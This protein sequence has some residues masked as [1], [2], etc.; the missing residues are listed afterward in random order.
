MARNPTHY[1]RLA[2]LLILM[3]GLGIFAASFGGTLQRSFEERA[4]YETG[5]DV[6][7]EGVILSSTGDSLPMRTVFEGLQPVED[8]TLA[9]RGFGS[10]LSKLLADSYIM[11]AVEGEKIREVGWFRDD[12]SESSMRSML[13]SLASDTLPVGIEAP[14]GA[15]SIGVTF[16]PD[17]P[18]PSVAVASRIRDANGRY[19][20]YIMGA[21]D[22][23]EWQTMEHSLDRPSRRGRRALRPQSPVSVVSFSI[24]ETSGRNRLRAGS[25]VI[26][27]IFARM[28]DGDRKVLEA[29]ESPSEWTMLRSVPEADA[30]LLKPADF[31]MNNSSAVNLIWAEG[32]PLVSRGIFHGPPLEPLPAI[33]SSRFIKNSG[34]SDGRYDRGLDTGPPLLRS[35]LV[36]EMDYFPTLNTFTRS[37]LSDRARVAGGIHQP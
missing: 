13:G 12:F 1:A 29:F 36:G 7:L 37:Y 2:L 30:D 16:K 19:F 4:L 15:S 21:M 18:H 33:A 8:V 10:D 25:M 20:T 24:F 35:S 22:D 34:H 5:A 6:R 3:A 26:D 9:F 17:R 28:P 23:G 32:R 14:D 31:G 11:F 27:E